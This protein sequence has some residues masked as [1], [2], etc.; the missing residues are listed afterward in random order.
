MPDHRPL[1]RLESLETSDLR[2]VAGA[3]LGDGIGADCAVVPGDVY[4][5]RP[6]AA[7]MPRRT[8]AIGAHT[9]AGDVVAASSEIGAPG[10]TVEITECHSL[11]CARGRVVEVLLVR[12]LGAG[13]GHVHAVPLGPLVPGMEY[14]AIRSDRAAGPQRLVDLGAIRFH[15]DTRVTLA[16]GTQ[17]R[18][19]DLQ[20]G[21][22][23]RTRDH[24]AQP[25]RAVVPDTWRAN[26]DAAW[27][28]I[29]ASVFG[30]ERALHLSSGQRVFV[31]RN[32]DE[33]GGDMRF[34]AD[35]L[36]N[37][38]TITREAAVFADGFRLI[39]ERAEIVFAEGIAVDTLPAPE[40]AGTDEP[41]EAQAPAAARRDPGTRLR[42]L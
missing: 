31:W 37:D 41:H 30:T 3:N 1:L 22:H 27:I 33:I 12:V 23:L 18:V 19:A 40:P 13:R 39:F 15:P 14:V 2:V 21:D 28:R 42:G 38:D 32:R 36:V 34:R 26:G 5:L 35:L 11:M 20:A 10:D 29:A 24:G 6:A 9:G 16:S 4:R 17:C 8:L 7:C 25:L